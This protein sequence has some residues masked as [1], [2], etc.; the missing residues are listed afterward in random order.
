MN[1]RHDIVI[2]TNDARVVGGEVDGLV[3]ELRGEVGQVPLAL[4]PGPVGR[5]DLLLLQQRPV[6]C[7]AIET[8]WVMWGQIRGGYLEEGVRHYLDKPRLSV[9]AEPVSWVLVQEALE[10]RSSLDGQW[11]RDPDGLL[12]YDLRNYV[13]TLDYFTKIFNK[14]IVYI[15]KKILILVLKIHSK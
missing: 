2:I 5:R 12:Q 8:S 13:T 1:T 3:C 15:K 14:E 4:Q 7:L 6:N 11:P 10:D 9:A